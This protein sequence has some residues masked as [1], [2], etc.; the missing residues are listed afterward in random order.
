MIPA[1]EIPC[2]EGCEILGYFIDI[3]NKELVRE[4]KKDAQANENAVRIL[5]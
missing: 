1:I 4:M 3:K 2:K 5:P